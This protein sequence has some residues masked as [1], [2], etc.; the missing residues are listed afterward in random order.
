MKNGQDIKCLHGMKVIS[1]IWI[2]IAH[3]F[4]ISISVPLTN[5][6]KFSEVRFIVISNMFISV[7]MLSTKIIKNIMPVVLNLLNVTKHLGW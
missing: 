1:I 7:N 5:W 3:R 6:R 4:V 2:I